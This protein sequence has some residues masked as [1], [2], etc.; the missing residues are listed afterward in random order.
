MMPFYF[1]LLSSCFNLPWR[2]CL[3]E[4]STHLQTKFYF[5]VALIHIKILLPGYSLLLIIFSMFHYS[6]NAVFLFIFSF[7]FWHISTRFDIISYLFFIMKASQEYPNFQIAQNSHWIL[8][9][10]KWIEETGD[11]RENKITDIHLAR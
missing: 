3:L 5:F 1:Q 4:C 7:D 11:L 8:S 6:K 10:S 2:I 9:C